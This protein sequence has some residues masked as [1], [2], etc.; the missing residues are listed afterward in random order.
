MK[1]M[2]SPKG[3]ATSLVFMC[4]TMDAPA[5][6]SVAF[7][8]TSEVMIHMYLLFVSCFNEKILFAEILHIAQT[9]NDTCVL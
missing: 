1:I 7:K 6:L 2:G 5:L 4:L 8:S 9:I 3:S